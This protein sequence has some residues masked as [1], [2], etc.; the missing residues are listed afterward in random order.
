MWYQHSHMLEDIDEEKPGENRYM[1][2]QKD[3]GNLMDGACK[4]QRGFKGNSHKMKTATQN[5]EQIDEILWK[6]EEGVLEN[7]GAYLEQES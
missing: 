5:K 4:Q 3:T 1:V 7:Q 2:Q 6:H